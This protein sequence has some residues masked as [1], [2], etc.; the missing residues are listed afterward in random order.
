MTSDYG[1]TIMPQQQK[2]SLMPNTKK[3]KVTEKSVFAWK[4][5]CKS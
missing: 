2:L 5:N 4:I 1:Y 3:K